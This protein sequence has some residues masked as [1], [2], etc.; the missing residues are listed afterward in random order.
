MVPEG[1]RVGEGQAGGHCGDTQAFLLPDSKVRKN[2]KR[3]LNAEN[4]LRVDG[5]MGERENR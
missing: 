5:S 1:G 2:H 3:L 4:K